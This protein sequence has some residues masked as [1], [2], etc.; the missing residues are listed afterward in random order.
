MCLMN[1]NLIVTAM[2]GQTRVKAE[3]IAMMTAFLMP[4]VSTTAGVPATLPW[5]RHRLAGLHRPDEGA[6]DG[7]LRRVARGDGQDG[8]PHKVSAAALHQRPNAR[9][10]CG[11][12]ERLCPFH[13]LRPCSNAVAVRREVVREG[14][15]G[16]HEDADFA[17]G[18]AAGAL[19]KGH[20]VGGGSRAGGQL[21]LVVG[22][23]LQA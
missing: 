21:G 15:S 9:R 17:L 22:L 2:V 14:G 16:A 10:D 6:L 3:Q 7:A 1:A 23:R 18:D 4:A 11:L 20:D 19:G 5:R 13:C 12:V 8:K